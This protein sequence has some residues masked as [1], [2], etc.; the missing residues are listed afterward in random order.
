MK[1]NSKVTRRDAIKMTGTGVA[2]SMMSFNSFPQPFAKKNNLIVIENKKEGSNDWQLT[3]VRQDSSN[4]R[5]PFI[6]GYCSKQSV[7]GGE[8]IDIM[9]SV[10][11][12]DQFKLE[13][14]RTG[15]Y[16]GRGARLMKIY[17]SLQGFEQLTPEP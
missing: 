17:D 8:S 12:N 3:R 7:K 15:Y 1:K 14:F 10:S 9:V 16:G 5:S 2:L 6:E 13:I 4:H 11:T